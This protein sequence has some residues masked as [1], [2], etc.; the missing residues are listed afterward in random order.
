[1]VPTLERLLSSKV[2]AAVLHLLFLEE[3]RELH[4]RELARQAGLS[5]G[6]VRQELARLAGL[7]VVTARRSGNRTY[8]RAETSHA[9]HRDLRGL[10]LKTSGVAGVLRDALAGDEIPVAFIF[11]STAAGTDRAGSDVDLMVI[12]SLSLRELTSRL[13]G[14]AERLE[15]EVNPHVFTAKEWAERRRRGDHFLTSVMAAPR[16][17]VKGDERELEAVGRRVAADRRSG[18]R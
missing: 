17:F 14:V 5:D 6:T 16:T 9:L 2:K 7:G 3:G 12:G 4:V 13:S 11:G 15:R 1:M 10:V 8:Y 18:A